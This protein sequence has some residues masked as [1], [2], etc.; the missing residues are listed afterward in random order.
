M[1]SRVAFAA[2]A[3][4]AA[5]T[6]PLSGQSGRQAAP[7]GGGEAS[8]VV[9]IENVARRV[10]PLP[11]GIAADIPLSSGVWAL[12]SG[13]NPILSP[14]EVQPGIGLQGLAE[15][16]MAGAFAP[17]LQGLP[18][19][20]ASGAFE[21]PLGR[22]RGRMVTSQAEGGGANTSRMLQA[23]QHFEFTFTARPGD[24]LSLA[25]MIAQSNDGLIATGPEGIPLFTADGR[26]VSGNLTADL[27]LWDAGT[28]VNEEPGRG[29]NQGLRQRAPHAGDR[30]RRPVRPLAE[31]EFGDRWPPVDRIV[32]LTITARR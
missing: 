2:V 16:G 20:R 19:V 6:A 9:R 24:R 32:R 15:A 10:L 5:G 22:A 11:T 7:S 29:R 25:L 27:F 17:N 1:Q 21:T 28:E 3:L 18:G 4:L 8:F 13:R 30:E 14:G 31:A 12:H 26:P 23:G